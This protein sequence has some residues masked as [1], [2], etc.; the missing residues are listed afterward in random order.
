MRTSLLLLA[1]LAV[2]SSVD[3]TAQSTAPS[4]LVGTWQLVLVDNVLSD[5]SRVHIYGPTPQGLAVFDASGHY[6]IH[7]LSAGRPKFA[8]NDKAKGTPEEYRAAVQGSNSHYGTYRVSEGDGTVVLHVVGATFA[9][10]EGAD[11]TWPFTV[12]GD[13]LTITVPHPTTGGPG[14]KGEIVYRRVSHD[15]LLQGTWT[16]VRAEV[17]HPDG[18]TVV[19]PLYGDGAKGLLIVDDQGRYSL[20]IFRPDRPKFAS[21]DKT[22]GS[23]DEYQAAVLGTSTHFGRIVVDTAAHALLFHIDYGSLPNQDDTDQ[24]RVFQLVNGELSYK[25]PP[26]PDGSSSVSVW[27]RAPE[28]YGP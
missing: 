21:N 24:K 25:I 16:L 11:L 26:R 22:K 12:N 9:N 17:I 8:S 27:R 18:T 13:Q 15:H 5:G 6:S 4:R 3:A 28:S 23:P 1:S 2:L 7:I 20:Q 19:D 14:A 10:W